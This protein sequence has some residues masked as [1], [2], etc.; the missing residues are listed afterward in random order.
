MHIVERQILPQNFVFNQIVINRP[1]IGKIEEN[2]IG[3]DRVRSALLITEYQ[4][5]PVMQI[6]K[7]RSERKYGKH[8]NDVSNM[9]KDNYEMAVCARLCHIV[10]FKR[11]R[12]YSH[13]L[14][15][16]CLCGQVV[17]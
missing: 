10:A 15:R 17:G 6:L 11:L 1:V 2:V 5:D 13:E 8:T 14:L 16:R 7:H 4:I 3:F 9:V 12:I